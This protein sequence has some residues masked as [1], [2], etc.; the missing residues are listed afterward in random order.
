MKAYTLYIALLAAVTFSFGS[1][2][3]KLDNW[4]YPA[5]VVSGKFLYNGQPVLIMG[6]SSDVVGANMLQL[7]QTG[8]G[9]W[10]PG[11]IKMFAKED[12]TYT[13][14]AFNGDYYLTITP[15]RGPWMP[16]KDTIRFT[17]SEKKTDANFTVTPY[18][19]MAN[20]SSAFQDSVFTAKFDLQKVV[21]AAVL[22][23]VVIQMSPTAIVDNVSKVYET[24][25]ASLVPGTNTISL[26][27]KTLTLA[28]KSAISKTGFTFA[29]VGVKT[30]GATDLLYSPTMQLK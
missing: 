21:P 20:Y 29:R 9:K 3:K 5:S 24:S 27:L 1:C 7:S 6:T 16:N 2:S 11:Y 23:K 8:P 25:F 19:W 17:L 28:Q 14:N 26:N 4:E 30:A 15:G 18:F 22:E 12:G 13:I 10:D